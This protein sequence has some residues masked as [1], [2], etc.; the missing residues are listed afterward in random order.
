M[1]KILGQALVPSGATVIFNLLSFF[2]ENF[3]AN[4]IPK[5]GASSYDFGVG[6]V[7]AIFGIGITASGA[8]ISKGLINLSMILLLGLVFLELLA[9]AIWDW[10]K[11][12][13]IV[14]VDAVSFVCL[15]IAIGVS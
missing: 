2:F 8:H 14:L 10:D 3:H 1:G 4:P 15:C 5:P 11:L 12:S 7:F 6:C 9:P 13:M